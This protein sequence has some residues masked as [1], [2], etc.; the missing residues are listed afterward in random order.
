[1][2]PRLPKPVLVFLVIVV[3]GTITAL[4]T[5]AMPPAQ[6]QAASTATSSTP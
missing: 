3:I 5:T 4:V 6:H 2:L 1:M